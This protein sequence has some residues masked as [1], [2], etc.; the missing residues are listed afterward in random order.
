V[1]ERHGRAR[2][3]AVH[4]STAFT[5]MRRYGAAVASSGIALL[6]AL[7]SVRLLGSGAPELHLA[8][9]MFSAWYGG[10]GPGLLAT[11][12]GALSLDYFFEAP[13]YSLA[14]SDPVRLLQS[15]LAFLGVAGL[16]SWLSTNLRRSRQRAER[17]QQQAQAALSVRDDVLRAISHDLRQPLTIIRLVAGT[18]QEQLEDVATPERPSLLAGL[19]RMEAHATKMAGLIADLL[20]VARLQDGTPLPLDRQPTDLVA[21]A[22]Q[23]AAEH[24]PGTERHV[25]SVCAPARA[26]CGLWDPRRLERVLDNLLA[27]A[28]KYSPSGGAIEVEV[29]LPS[30]ELARLVVRDHGPGVPPAERA[31][32]F[33]RFYRAPGGGSVGGFGLGLYICRQFIELHGGRIAAEFPPT[34][35]RVSS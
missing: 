28:I 18:L 15:V 31:R 30:P 1:Q 26:V 17:A 10:L 35:G 13:R 33:E 4:A 11:V 20:E 22:R 34:G 3:L 16:I 14:I 19:A 5:V 8:A 32:L 2:E 12:L 27:N 23:A 29:T 7:V 6:L 25:I 24:Q 21:L 9:V